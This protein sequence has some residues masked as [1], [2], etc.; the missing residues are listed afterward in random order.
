MRGSLYGIALALSFG[1]GAVAQEKLSV[2]VTVHIQGNG[3]IKGKEEEWVGARGEPKRI[4]G[5]MVKKRSGHKNVDI[6]YR[7]DFWQPNDNWLSSTVHE[8]QN[9]GSNV[10]LRGKPITGFSV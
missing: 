10:D 1:S 2:D 3:D 8:G 4:G 7:C 5:M 6:V 9:C